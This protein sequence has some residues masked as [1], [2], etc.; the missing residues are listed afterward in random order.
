MKTKQ[1]VTS[2]QFKEVEY[3]TETE[4]LIL[5]FNNDKRYQYENVPAEVFRALIESDSL[6]KYF[7]ANIKS[8]PVYKYKLI[9]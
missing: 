4:L 2:S 8:N 7:I 5:T 9:S 1:Q 6:G 3:D